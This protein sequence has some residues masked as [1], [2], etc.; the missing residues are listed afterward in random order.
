MERGD[1]VGVDL[2]R[3]LQQQPRGVE[4][5]GRPVLGDRF[6]QIGEQPGG[7]PVGIPS[8]RGRQIEL[9]QLPETLNGGGLELIE[10]PRRGPRALD[11]AT[12]GETQ[13]R[14][15]DECLGIQLGELRCRS[16]LDRPQTTRR[17][18]R[19]GDQDLADREAEGAT[20]QVG[21]G[22]AHERTADGSRSNTTASAGT[23]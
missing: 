1:V 23:P 20:R 13:K 5:L 18:V 22:P 6:G 4:S 19:F 3:L 14:P 16:R 21:Q 8:A 10:A 2:D 12:S 15:P 7:D 9:A 11:V 17:G